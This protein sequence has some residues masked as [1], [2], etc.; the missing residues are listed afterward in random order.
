MDKSESGI[1][2]SLACLLA[3]QG[4][5][6]SDIEAALRYSHRKAGLPSRTPIIGAL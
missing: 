5:D 3:L 6:G 1:E 4:I 2:A